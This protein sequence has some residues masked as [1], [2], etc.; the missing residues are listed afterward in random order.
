[1]HYPQREPT[2]PGYT[3][4]CGSLRM[5][6]NSPD[7]RRVESAAEPH[8]R[9]A[10]IDIANQQLDAALASITRAFLAAHPPPNKL[11]TFDLTLGEIG[12]TSRIAHQ[13]ERTLGIVTVRDLLNHTPEQLAAVPNIAEESLKNIQRAIKELKLK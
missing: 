13:L 6:I 8:I 7:F 9:A 5:D 12:I 10:L 4:P 3:T 2:R 1:M 11:N